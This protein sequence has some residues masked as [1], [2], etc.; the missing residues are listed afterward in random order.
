M[1]VDWFSKGWQSWSLCMML[2]ALD[3]NLRP[4]ML[5]LERYWERYLA[6]ESLLEK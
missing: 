3:K 2:C 6:V 5:A 4:D 1:D